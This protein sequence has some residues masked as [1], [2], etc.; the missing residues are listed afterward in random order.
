MVSAPP[1]T[2]NHWIGCLLSTIYELTWPVEGAH[3]A[4][5]TPETFAAFVEA[6]NF[7]DDA[8]FHHHAKYTARLC[9]VID[10]IPAH[11]VTL[12]RDPYDVFVSMYFWEQERSAR[13][14]GR[15]QPRPR[16]AMYGKAIDHDDVLGFLANSFGGHINRALGWRHSGRAIPIRYEELH[17]NPVGSLLRVTSE[18]SPVSE[19]TIARALEVCRADRVRQQDEKMAWHVRAARVGDSRGKLTEAHLAIFREQHGD[20]IRE[21]GYEVR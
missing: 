10:A 2:G 3:A 1:K 4:V 19:A 18:I 6:G 21:L 8:M 20:L 12:C 11:N 9:N 14:M 13:G 17:E 15:S 7:P 16:H 5:S